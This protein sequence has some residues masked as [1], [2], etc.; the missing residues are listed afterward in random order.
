[1]YIVLSSISIYTLSGMYIV[2]FFG[3]QIDSRGGV[4]GMCSTS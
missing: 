1:M 3:F 2:S 4:G